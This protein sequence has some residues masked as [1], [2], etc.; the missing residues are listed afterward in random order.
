M[1][2]NEIVAAAR[3]LIGTPFLHQG[4]NEFGMDCVGMVQKVGDKFAVPYEDLTGYAR[5]PTNIKFLQHLRKYLNRASISGDRNG[6]VGVFRQSVYPCHIGIFAVTDGILTL[7]NSRADRRKVVE[8]IYSDGDFYLV[9]LLS[10][11]GLED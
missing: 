1:K 3:T 4:R 5:A 2:R 10:F 11:P 7:I 6:M 9:E 8:E